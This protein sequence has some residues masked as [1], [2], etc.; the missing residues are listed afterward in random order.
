MNSSAKTVS[1]SKYVN[2]NI[3]WLG[4]TVSLVLHSHTCC[5]KSQDS[6]TPSIIVYNEHNLHH[7]L[8]FS[9]CQK[10][11]LAHADETVWNKKKK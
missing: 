7:A 1:R 10:W 6:L 8:S 3:A 11:N 5:P 2:N 9:R 4:L